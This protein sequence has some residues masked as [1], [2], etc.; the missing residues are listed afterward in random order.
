MKILHNTRNNRNPENNFFYRFF[1]FIIWFSVSLYF[2]SSF[3]ITTHKPTI[4]RTTISQSKPSRALIEQPSINFSALKDNHG[5]PISEPCENPNTRFKSSC[6]LISLLLIFF[7]SQ[8]RSRGWRFMYTICRRNST[9]SGW[10]TSGAAAICS[11]R[12]WRFTGRWWAAMLEH[13]THLR[14]TFSSSLS[15]S[16][17]ISAKLTDSPPS[18]MPA[19]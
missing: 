7:F 19:L 14:L 2:L 18:A 4:S 3:F 13:L 10:R 11:R 8:V 16:H 1:K 5:K 6:F 12:R 9:A 15:T 17:A